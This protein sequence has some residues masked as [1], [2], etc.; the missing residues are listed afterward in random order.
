[1]LP[2][3]RR[4]D[5]LTVETMK[6]EVEKLLD[7]NILSRVTDEG[8]QYAALM[9]LVRKQGTTEKRFCAEFQLLNQFLLPDAWNPPNI[10]DIIQRVGSKKIFSVLDLKV[11]YYQIRLGSKTK[12]LCRIRTP[13]GVFQFER[14]PM[15]TS[16]SASHMQRILE[17][18]ILSIP[19]A[20]WTI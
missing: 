4:Y 3:V 7:A 14:M 16:P 2:K 15:G 5:D 17:Q 8:G 12:R 6:S 9:L 10:D 11:A 19:V 18:Y 20:I 13:F 1:V